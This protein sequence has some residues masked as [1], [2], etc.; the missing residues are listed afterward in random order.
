MDTAASL[1]GCLVGLCAPAGPGTPFATPALAV[2][3]TLRLLLSVAALSI[4]WFT[5][6]SAA[7][8]WVPAR[9]RARYAALGLFAAA[10]VGTE[11]AH[12]GDAAHYRLLLNL[13]GVLAALAGLREPPSPDEEG[14]DEPPADAGRH[15]A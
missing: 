7:A 15:A 2:L 14:V 5:V 9:Q 12:L 1:A 10:T 4:V 11:L 13:A 3:D 8:R 6:R